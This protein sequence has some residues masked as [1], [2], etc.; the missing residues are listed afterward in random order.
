MCQEVRVS[1]IQNQIDM[2]PAAFSLGN[3]QIEIRGTVSAYSFRELNVNV[4]RCA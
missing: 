4:S 1:M 2:Y 3:H